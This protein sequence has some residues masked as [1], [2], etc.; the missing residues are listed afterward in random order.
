MSDKY[1]KIKDEE[2]HN[3]LLQSGMFFEFHPELTGDWDVDSKVINPTKVKK[4]KRTKKQDKVGQ[5]TYEQF[6]GFSQILQSIEQKQNAI[7]YVLQL[8]DPEGEYFIGVIN[9]EIDEMVKLVD[10]L[11]DVECQWFSWF[12]FED[13]FG[14]NGLECGYKDEL[15][16]ICDERDMFEFLKLIEE[17]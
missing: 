15:Y 3:L 17:K 2:S 9:R 1:G 13:D 11:I 8:I 6:L 5:L 4:T 10:S 12:V 7:K 16:P 14:K